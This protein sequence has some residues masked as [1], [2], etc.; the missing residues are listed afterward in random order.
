MCIRARVALARLGGKNSNK[1][2]AW[3]SL[4]LGVCVCRSRCAIVGTRQVA[5]LFGAESGHLPSLTLADLT[6]NLSQRAASLGDKLPLFHGLYK[7]L[8][9]SARL[10]ASSTDEF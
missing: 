3:P 7:T 1:E 9:P 6:N 8:V 2:Q 10:Q 5:L 4:S